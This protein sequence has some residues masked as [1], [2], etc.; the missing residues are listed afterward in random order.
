MNVALAEIGHNKPPEALGFASD[1]MILLSDWMKEHPV[2][3][4]AHDAH[5]AKKLLDSAKA[6]AGDIEAERDGKVRP[7]NTAIADINFRYKAVHN[8]DSKKPGLLDKIV[9]ELKA[10]LTAFVKAEEARREHEAAAKHHNAE[11]AERLSL[12]A[13]QREREAIDNAR[14]GEL[15]VDV[16]AVV[17]EADALAAAHARAE[18][19]AARADRDAH[20]KIGGGWGRSVSLRTKETL[21]LTHP[22]VAIKTMGVTD[23]IREAILS[24]ARDYR[25]EKGTLPEGV[26][27]Q[28]IREI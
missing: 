21:I 23:K 10:R 18:R 14:A 12:E 1:T 13:A 9:N 22:M 4:T 15:G 24:A 2:I 28:T 3:Q 8:T 5:E 25:S 19:E 7:L 6:T 11:E 17:V 20:V 26:V 27:S 16:T